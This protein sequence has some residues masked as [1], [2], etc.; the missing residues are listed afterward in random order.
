MTIRRT[1]SNSVDAS[2]GSLD[3]P[4]KDTSKINNIS[5]ALSSVRVRAPSVC[6]RFLRLRY[7]TPS[8][9]YTGPES[10]GRDSLFRSRDQRAALRARARDLHSPSIIFAPYARTRVYISGGRKEAAA[11]RGFAH[12][13][14]E[15]VYNLTPRIS[16]K[17]TRLC[18]HNIFAGNKNIKANE[19]N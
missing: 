18:A 3:T 13:E 7:R 16:Y 2:G 19:S 10:R 12:R 1:C 8:S 14:R 4:A 11:P 17:Y 9:L 6:C 15:D 5:P